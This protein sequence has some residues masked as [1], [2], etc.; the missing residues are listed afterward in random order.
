MQDPVLTRMYV[1]YIQVLVTRKSGN[2]WGGESLRINVK[3]NLL[4]LIRVL[5]H[6]TV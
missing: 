2:F 3:D 5:L 6:P 1:F 4:F